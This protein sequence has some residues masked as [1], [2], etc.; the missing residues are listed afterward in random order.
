MKPLTGRRI[1]ITRALHQAGSLQSLLQAM[2]AEVIAAPSIEIVPP[3]SYAQL[4][5]ALFHIARYDWLI[6]TSANAV[7]AI[8]ERLQVLRI[9][10]NAFGGL[11][12]AAV[13]PA[14]ARTLEKYGW[15]VSAIP[16]EYVAESV[17]ALLREKI[18]GKRILLVR[19]KVARDVIPNELTRLGAEV[20][21]AEAYQTVMP[22]GAS[23]QVRSI[24]A[25][26]AKVPDAIT[27]TSSS[28]AKNFFFLLRAAGSLGLPEHM[29][30][31]S[32]GPIT[33]ETLRMHGIKPHVEARDHSVPGL[34]DAITQYY[35]GKR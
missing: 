3:A 6:V 1:L 7:S 27:F 34:V 28:T 25:D 20:H 33:S 32:I 2:G 12:I 4:D 23:E 17:V 35:A 30:V 26:S 22:P 16:R 11:Q 5:D 10:D 8:A 21:I 15:P 29:V 31:A 14:T 9:G 19:A 18:A 13:G 24:F